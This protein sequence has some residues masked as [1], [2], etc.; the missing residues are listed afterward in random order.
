MRPVFQIICFLLAITVPALTTR[1]LS[2]EFRSGNMQLLAA[3]AVPP[4]Q[5]ALGKFFFSLFFVLVLLICTL[6]LP[7]LLLHY[8]TPDM[9]EVLCGYIGLLFAG[10]FF[11]SVGLLASSLTRSAVIALIITLAILLGLFFLPTDEQ[12]QTSAL[13][14]VSVFGHFANF[15]RGVLDTSDLVFFLVATLFF[16]VL[17]VKVLGLRQRI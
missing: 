12:T 15:A 7:L 10:T 3:S 2:G 6:H 13:A 11:A 14:A 4:Y 9:G 5:I 1:L 8:G 16:V 17:T